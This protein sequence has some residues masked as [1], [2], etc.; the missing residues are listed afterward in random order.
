MARAPIV[1]F[2][3]A[4][5]GCGAVG[6][7]NGQPTTAGA[8]VP[9]SGASVARGPATARAAV[10]NGDSLAIYLRTMRDLVEGDAVV[11]ADTFMSVAEAADF[12]P[13]TT[14]RLNLA[15]ALATPG[16]PSSNPASAQRMLSELLAAGAALLPE[17]RILAVVHLKEVEQ[18]LV[19]DAEAQRLQ[20]EAAAATLR[21]N[22]Q[23][24]RRL[25]DL[26]EEN[27]RL[28]TEL[29]AAQ[30]KLDAITNIERSIRERENDS[31]P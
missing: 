20:Q 3:F 17:E 11:Q 5:A 16:H 10:V 18:R 9:R 7:S 28:R 6:A 25:Q 19:L 27:E 24:A 4:L 22:N 26:I 2:A 1:I 29:D 12:E 30:Q 31:D 13:T 8:S 14:N 21:R 15:L 23:S